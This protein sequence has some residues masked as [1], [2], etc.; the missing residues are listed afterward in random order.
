MAKCRNSES[1]E[2]VL[3]RSE[4]SDTPRREEHQELASTLGQKTTKRIN[5]V[6]KALS[7]NEAL[8]V[9][10][11]ELFDM[12]YTEVAEVLCKTEGNIRKAYSQGKRRLGEKVR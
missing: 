2:L 1:G 7:P 10:A 3:Y 9:L 4:E 12:S 11:R 6:I 5:Q 8:V